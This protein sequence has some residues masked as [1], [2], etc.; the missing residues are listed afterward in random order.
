MSQ[1]RQNTIAP[2]AGANI[3]DILLTTE[4]D[5]Y[6]ASRREIVDIWLTQ[7]PPAAGT[8]QVSVQAGSRLFANRQVPPNTTGRTPVEPITTQDP[9]VRVGLNAGER[10]QISVLNT[11]AANAGSLSYV[12]ESNPA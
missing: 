5:P 3:R 10:L 12:I 7:R 4:Q 8:L 11:D 1:V 9:K 6:V 2:A